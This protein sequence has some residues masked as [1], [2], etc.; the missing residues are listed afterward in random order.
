MIHLSAL[1]GEQVGGEVEECRLAG[2]VAPEQA[3]DASVAEVGR[4]VVQHKRAVA[5]VAE[6][7]IF[8]FEYSVIVE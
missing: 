8:Y 6:G 5:A 4:K 3:V 7:D 1:R 2:A